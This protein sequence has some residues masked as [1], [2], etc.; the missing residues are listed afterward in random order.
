MDVMGDFCDVVTYIDVKNGGL[1]LPLVKVLNPVFKV[2]VILEVKQENDIGILCTNSHT[3]KQNNDIEPEL[4]RLQKEEWRA[5]R[6]SEV[7]KESI[8]GSMVGISLENGI[9]I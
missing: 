8:L 1:I 3:Q 4:V 5:V 2:F 6:T 7:V 9:N